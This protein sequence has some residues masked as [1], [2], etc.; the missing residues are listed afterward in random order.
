MKRT[1]GRPPR[2]LERLDYKAGG[3]ILDN[4]DAQAIVRM[5]EK[6]GG[7]L[8]MFV[9]TFDRRNGK[10]ETVLARVLYIL[11]QPE[12]EEYYRNWYQL[13][14]CFRTAKMA[15]L[16]KDALAELE[17]MP[18]PTEK[19]SIKDWITY[20]NFWSKGAVK[21]EAP[22]KRGG[23]QPQSNPELD[24]VKAMVEKMQNAGSETDSE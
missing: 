19:T 18:K 24:V 15:L 12:N 6:C 16:E 14:E 17:K 22:Q 20:A 11:K 7:D 13:I 2:P 21:D 9:G 1:G 23:A 5:M 8:E 3:I 10:K 4:M